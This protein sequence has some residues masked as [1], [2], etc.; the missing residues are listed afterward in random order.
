[1]I[2]YFILIFLLSAEF[3]LFSSIN[4]DDIKETIFKIFFYIVIFGLL[5]LVSFVMIPSEVKTKPNTIKKIINDYQ[6]GYIKY[7]INEERDMNNN[8]IYC[9]TLF[10]YEKN[11]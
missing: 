3:V 7:K 6:N 4:T 8:I 5:C 1:M 11:K 9:D 2:I 10:F